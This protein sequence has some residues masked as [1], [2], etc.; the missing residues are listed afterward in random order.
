MIGYSATYQAHQDI[1][2]VL[3]RLVV[4]NLAL[5]HRFDCDLDSCTQ[6]ERKNV[7]TNALAELK[8]ELKVDLTFQN[9]PV[10]LFKAR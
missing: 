6:R 1:N 10:C 5:L 4:L 2:L 7:N 9:L 3:E 8:R